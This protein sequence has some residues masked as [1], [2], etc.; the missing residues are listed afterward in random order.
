MAVIAES[1]AKGDVH[2]T[3][4]LPNGDLMERMLLVED[5]L[6]ECVHLHDLNENILANFTSE[7][8]DFLVSGK[9][10][11]RYRCLACRT[12][13][14]FGNPLQFSETFTVKFEHRP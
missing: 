12:I 10:A 4:E 7:F 5:D 9:T 14:K 1:L 13:T 2:C 6:E 11:K 3:I 8:Y